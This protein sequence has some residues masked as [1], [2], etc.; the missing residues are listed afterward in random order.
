M[1]SG[2][3]PIRRF[4]VIAAVVSLAAINECPAGPVSCTFFVDKDHPQANDGNLGTSAKPFATIQAGASAAIHPGDT[5]CVKPGEKPYRESFQGY[6]QSNIRAIKPAASGQRGSPITFTAYPEGAP[7]II[8]QKFDLSAGSV[9]AR[10]PQQVFG[11]FIYGHDYITIRGFEIRN[12]HSGIFTQRV[13]RPKEGVYD[14]PSHIVVEECHIHDIR[15]LRG[16]IGAIQPNDCYNCLIRNNRI[17]DVAFFREKTTPAIVSDKTNLNIAGIHS[18]SMLNTEIAGN[19]ISRASAGIYFKSWTN[20]P[21]NQ[22]GSAGGLRASL[23]VGEPQLPPPVTARDRGMVVRHNNIFDVRTGVFIAPSGGNGREAVQGKANK[24]PG[25]HNIDIYENN[26][27]STADAAVYFGAAQARMNYALFTSVSAT[28]DQSNGL[29]FYSNTV[30]AHNGV[31]IDAVTDVNI[32]NNFFSVSRLK[33]VKSRPGIAIQTRYTSVTAGASLEKGKS[34]NLG[35]MDNPF[36]VQECNP[37]ADPALQ[38]PPYVSS[39]PYINA[40]NGDNEFFCTDNLRWTAELGLVDFNYYHTDSV[41]ELNAFSHGQASTGRLIHWRSNFSDWTFLRREAVFGLSE[42]GPDEH[43][44]AAV[45]PHGGV[46]QGVVIQPG[47][48]VEIDTAD[49]ELFKP[50]HPDLVGTGRVGGVATGAPTNIG[51]VP[52]PQG[53]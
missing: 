42:D 28:A 29:N 38:A 3:R 15:R 48:G 31:S 14:P 44:S 40:V 19:E 35:T 45:L 5:V 30:I 12:A 49:S 7:V 37:A 26:F 36:L 10:P 17:H 52:Q 51:S 25:F 27:F 1:R 46:F 4:F 41:F 13:N 22:P 23:G 9:A 18:F 50:L 11:F 16:N 2:F 8:D 21:D 34:L 6:P 24:N 32:Y 47:K 43:S 20:Q 53:Q 33:G 39:P